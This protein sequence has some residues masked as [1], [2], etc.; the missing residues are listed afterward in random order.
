M[1]ARASAASRAQWTVPPA[2]V[3]RLFK[4]LKIGAEIRESMSAD[5]CGRGAQFLPVGLFGNKQCALGLDHI[6]GVGDIFAQLRVAAGS[7]ARRW[8]TEAQ[9]ADP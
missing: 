4:L 7:A 5:G 3:Q 2:A 9:C 6:G 8:E 1:M